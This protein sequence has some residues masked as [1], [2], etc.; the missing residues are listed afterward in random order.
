V[1]VSLISNGLKNEA[2]S[3]TTVTRNMRHQFQCS[4]VLITRVP[5]VC[6]PARCEITKAAWGETR[7]CV[8]S[9]R[10][11]YFVVNLYFKSFC[12]SSDTGLP[13]PSHSQGVRYLDETAVYESCCTTSG[14]ES[15]KFHRLKKW[16]L[17]GM[18]EYGS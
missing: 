4:E 7:L 9:S 3:E 10:L 5:S 6:Q 1:D 16:A 8:V 14:I 13:S 15:L 11:K 17:L 18:E 2:C 12:A